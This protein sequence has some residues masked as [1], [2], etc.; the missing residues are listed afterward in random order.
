VRVV[1]EM[2]FAGY[3]LVVWEIVEF[4]RREDIYCEGRGSAAN[5]AVCYVLGITAVDAVRLE[6]LFE[7]FLSPHRD[8][9]PD[10]DLDIENGRRDEVIQ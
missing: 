7:R 1:E 2:S 10:I 5:S 3:F 8:G 6:L 9:P 4:C